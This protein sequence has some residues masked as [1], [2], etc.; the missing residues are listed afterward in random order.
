MPQGIGLYLGA[1]LGTGIL[2]LP[3]VGAQTAGP[4]SL[5]A[6]VAL[7]V[8]SVPL[9]L[10]YAALSQSRPDAAG[11]SESVERAFGARWGAVAGWLF[12]AQ[13]PTGLVIV[14]LVA[15][16]YAAT[17]LGQPT[18]VVP[19]G[20]VL[21]A[22]AL[23][24]NLV[25]LRLSA[26]VQLVALA[27]IV[28]GVIVVVTRALLHLRVQAFT[29]FFP[30]GLAPVGLAAAQL[31]WAFV[32]WEAITPLADEFRRP[33]DIWR[34]SVITLALVGLLYL[35]LSV[36]TIGT[37]A[38]G[39]GPS[40]QAD[41]ARMAVAVF[42]GFAAPVVG[43]GGFLLS[44]PTVN[45]YMAGMSRLAAALARR[46]QLPG[47]LGPTANGIPRRALVALSLV[48]VGALAAL[49]LARL[50]IARVLP[51][52]AANFI[53]IYVLSMAAAARLLPGLARYVAVVALVCCA[54]VLIFLG[55]VLVWPAAIA[56]AA[57]VYLRLFHDVRDQAPGD[58][59]VPTEHEQHHDRQ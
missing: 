46:R 42:G 37:H 14:T 2:F 26:N 57:L 12:L 32:G 34:A 22:C 18:W 38:Y 44:F 40:G 43:L 25:G 53:I 15:G 9:A 3:A 8:L 30:Y 10:S 29:P 27:V 47:W 52:P 1:V 11:F 4:A 31:F 45:A 36:A 39:S 55:P 6:W 19:T 56:V 5:L 33:A 16:Q 17:A 51:L 23:L 20:A 59:D 50:D 28:V 13:A 7:I 49:L 24:L 35:A 54:G 58:V 48:Y 41:I 21:V